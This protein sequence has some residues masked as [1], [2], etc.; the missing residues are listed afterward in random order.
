[1]FSRRNRLSLNDHPQKPMV[2]PPTKR[3][4]QPPCCNDHIF[5]RNY[6]PTTINYH[7]LASTS[8]LLPHHFQFSTIS[9]PFSPASTIAT[10][11]HRGTEKKRPLVPSSPASSAMKTKVSP[12]KRGVSAIFNTLSAAKAKTELKVCAELFAFQKLFGFVFGDSVDVISNHQSS[13]RKI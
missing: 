8:W 3:L 10:V 13:F 12:P 5:S 1:M 4:V 7:Q 6:Q 9:D 2:S 11:C